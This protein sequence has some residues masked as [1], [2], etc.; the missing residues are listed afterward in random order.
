[1]TERAYYLLTMPPRLSQNR[2]YHWKGPL[3]GTEPRWNN[4][5]G[6][7]A[8]WDPIYLWD[9]HPDKEP[10]AREQQQLKKEECCSDRSPILTMLPFAYGYTDYH[11]WGLQTMVMGTIL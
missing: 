5:D 9:H 10:Q 2:G 7:I 11:R 6:E 8:N 1:M 4:K 3:T